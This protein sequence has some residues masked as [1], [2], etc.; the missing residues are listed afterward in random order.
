GRDYPSRKT[1][2]TSGE[3]PLNGRQTG[4]G[5][6]LQLKASMQWSIQ[7]T[8]LYR[9]YT[10]MRQAAAHTMQARKESANACQMNYASGWS[11]TVLAKLPIMKLAAT[12]KQT[13]AAIYSPVAGQMRS[14]ITK[15]RSPKLETFHI[16]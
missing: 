4:C 10:P 8:K 7:W 11:E 9:N 5:Q 3:L 6:S 15:T 14:A 2:L 13:W 12:L 1:P 16:A